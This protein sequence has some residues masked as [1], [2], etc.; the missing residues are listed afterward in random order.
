MLAADLATALDPV[1][2]AEAAG[3]VPDPWQAQLLRS[4]APRVLLNCCRQAGKST[5]SAVLAVHTVLYQPGA[6]VLLLSPSLR[7]SQELF[8]K[9]LHVYRAAGRPVAPEAES[10]LRLELETGARIVSLPGTETTVRGYSGVDLLIVDEAARVKD[11]LY[12]SIRPMLAVSGGRLAALSTPFGTRGWWFESWRGAEAWERYEV[13]A[14]ACPRI[15]PEFL[16]EEQRN[17]G[18]FWFKQEY[19]CEFIDAQSQAFRRAD[20]DRAF[21]E[22]VTPWHL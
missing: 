8:R 5:M 12:Y 14:T 4:A 11:E 22:E 3:L 16:A 21:T 9:C 20:I 19:G 6:L 15:T 17:M 18:E 1:R 7:Q 13:P 2:L 10:A